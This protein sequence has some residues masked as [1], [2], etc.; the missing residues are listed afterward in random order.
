MTLSPKQA[1]EVLDNGQVRGAPGGP[2]IS[3]NIV[4]IARNAKDLSAQPGEANFTFL[5]P[6]FLPRYRGEVGVG[7]GSFA[8]DLVN[9][10]KGVPAL[11]SE[12]DKAFTGSVV[13]GIEAGAQTQALDDSIAIITRALLIFALVVTFAGLAWISTALAREQRRAAEDVAIIRELGMTNGEARALLAASVRARPY[14]PGQCSHSRSRCWC[15]L[16]S[17]S[18]SPGASIPI[19][20]F[21][22]TARCSSA[23]QP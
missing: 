21:T 14:S 16:C 9:G 7:T 5:S 15:R 13:P 8:V 23:A 3:L 18:A 6:A 19:S 22:S 12:I 20:A 10:V 4:G 1:A 11:R 2:K 17:R